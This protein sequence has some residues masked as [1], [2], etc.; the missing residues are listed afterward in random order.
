[1]ALI[2]DDEMRERTNKVGKRLRLVVRVEPEMHRHV[3]VRCAE[4]GSAINDRILDLLRREFGSP[5]T[6]RT[7]KKAL[8]EAGA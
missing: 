8:A 7:R 6:G 2:T 5:K 1:L 3:K 4:D